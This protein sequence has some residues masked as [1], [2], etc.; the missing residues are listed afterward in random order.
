MQQSDESALPGRSAPAVLL[1]AAC[2]GLLWL[3]LTLWLCT[4]APADTLSECAAKLLSGEIDLQGYLICDPGG[5]TTSSAAASPANAT[6]TTIV[7]TVSPL[8]S[9]STANGS[10]PVTGAR[11]A[12]LVA[13]GAALLVLGSAAVYGATNRRRRASED[14]SR[15]D[16]PQG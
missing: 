6:R 4:G 15:D 10:L 5:P 2:T 13:I 7:R 16:G 1:G 9:T 12:Q 3:G 8:S 11:D 14:L